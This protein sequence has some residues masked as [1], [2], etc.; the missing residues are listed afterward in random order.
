[1]ITMRIAAL[2]F[3]GIG[4]SG[5]ITYGNL[6]KNETIDKNSKDAII[7]V[8]VQPRYRVAI[9]RGT[10]VDG[11]IKFSNGGFATLNVFPEG[12]YIVGKVPAASSPDEYHINMI[13]PEG[14]GGFTP[15]YSPCGDEK[16]LSFAAPAGSVV[17]VGDINFSTN[18]SDLKIDYSTNLE[19]ARAFLSQQY[20]KLAARLEKQTPQAFPFAGSTCTPQHVAIPIIIY[21]GRG[22]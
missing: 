15:R 3:V 18:A 16:V 17:Y 9:G 8:G 5:C 4:L 11:Q 20:P 6:G 19:A 13:L 12:G 22:R 1:M 7:V 14:I 2:M 21:V 10:V